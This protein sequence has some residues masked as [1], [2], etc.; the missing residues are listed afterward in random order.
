MS[1]FLPSPNNYS[2]YAI[3]LAWVAALAPH[4]WAVNKHDAIVKKGGKKWD[5]ASASKPFFR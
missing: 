4:F 3:P 1:S 2:L 5:N